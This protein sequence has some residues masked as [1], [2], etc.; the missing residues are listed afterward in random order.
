[1]SDAWRGAVVRAVAFLSL[2]QKPK[3]KTALTGGF[4]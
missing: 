3:K 4:L 2:L 1:V